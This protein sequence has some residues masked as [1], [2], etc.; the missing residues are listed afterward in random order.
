MS[1]DCAK[2]ITTPKEI[3]PIISSDIKDIPN[4]ELS[5]T[6]GINTSSKYN[7]QYSIE[8][9]LL[10]TPT[11]FMQHAMED[12][13]VLYCCLIKTMSSQSPDI[14]TTDGKYADL[15]KQQSLNKY[16]TLFPETLPPELPPSDRVTH[17]IE[18]VPNAKIPP[19]KLY[20][21]SVSEIS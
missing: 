3:I 16:P 20:R 19:R 1:N 17:G 18:L 11:V 6:T 8:N 13:A 7:N 14:P 15:L 4:D 21:Q 10:C 12:E 2:S 9:A 5:Y